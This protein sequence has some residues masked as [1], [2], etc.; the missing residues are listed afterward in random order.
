MELA[1]VDQVAQRDGVRADR[2]GWKEGSSLLVLA[3]GGH[4][5]QRQIQGLHAFS[6]ETPSTDGGACAAGGPAGPLRGEGPE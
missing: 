5:I 2:A 3:Q 1:Q 4:L 6:V